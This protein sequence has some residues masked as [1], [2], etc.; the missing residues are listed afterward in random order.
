MGAQS[1]TV[2]LEHTSIIIE[3]IL[4]PG[5]LSRAQ[6][7]HAL[8]LLKSL[9]KRGE[10]TMKALVDEYGIIGHMNEIL[11]RDNG[12]AEIALSI[13]RIL[14]FDDYCVEKLLGH[15]EAINILLHIIQNPRYLITR[16]WDKE[17]S[18]ENLSL[19]VLYI[20]AKNIKYHNKFNKFDAIRV[21]TNLLP[22]TGHVAIKAALP[23]ILLMN[24]AA[25]NTGN[26]FRF[27]DVPIF[28]AP[29]PVMYESNNVLMTQLDIISGI[30]DLIEAAYRRQ[31]IEHFKFGR[32]DL[33]TLITI[34][35]ITCGDD[36]IRSLLVSECFKL[37]KILYDL[38]RDFHDVSIISI[39]M[40]ACSF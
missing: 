37:I 30:V 27:P 14:A 25:R 18:I 24:S 13:L 2:A 33:K 36:T 21:F 34:V 31:D 6:L 11:K 12:G 19:Y 26:M 17:G 9:C 32:Y 16:C 1:S 4:K 35:Y 28:S 23:S 40:R 10:D 15:F 22:I 8:K 3:K 5:E 20:C 7:I 38:L 29:Y 39:L